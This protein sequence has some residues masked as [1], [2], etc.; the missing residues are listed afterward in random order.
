MGGLYPALKVPE[1]RADTLCTRVRALI[2]AGRL[3]GN[4][5]VLALQSRAATQRLACS[6]Y[7]PRTNLN[8]DEGNEQ[9][10]IFV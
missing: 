9:N 5:T 7:E 1:K 10:M 8:L 6:S 4:L 2:V 3:A